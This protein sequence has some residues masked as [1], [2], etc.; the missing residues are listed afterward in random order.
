MQ[1]YMGDPAN[2]PG[3]VTAVYLGMDFKNYTN[4]VISA[5]VRYRFQERTG[6]IRARS[7]G[8]SACAFDSAPAFAVVPG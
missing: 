4:I 8:R 5:L 7:I 6:R 2:D 1:P 3:S